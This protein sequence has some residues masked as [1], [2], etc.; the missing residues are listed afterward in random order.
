M[1]DNNFMNDF[2]AKKDLLLKKVTNLVMN[3]VTPSV[4]PSEKFRTMKLTLMET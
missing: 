1:Y 4:L 3:V 2:N